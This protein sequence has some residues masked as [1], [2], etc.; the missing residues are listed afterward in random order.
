MTTETFANPYT[1]TYEN[2]RFAFATSR[3]TPRDVVEARAAAARRLRIGYYSPEQVALRAENVVRFERDMARAERADR[4]LEAAF[5][6]GAIKGL[7][8]V[9]HPVPLSALA[10]GTGVVCTYSC[11]DGVLPTPAQ[12]VIDCEQEAYAEALKLQ[13]RGYGDE[14]ADLFAMVAASRSARGVDTRL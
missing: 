9:S 1:D 8:G 3:N 5:A 14:A 6:S 2:R 12:N 4:A 10:D 7:V 11:C 13:R